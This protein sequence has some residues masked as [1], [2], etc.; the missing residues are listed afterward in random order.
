MVKDKS[1]V[2][3]QNNRN[4]LAQAHRTPNNCL[5]G[6]VQ[7]LTLR[8]NP[9]ENAWVVS[10]SG[11]QRGAVQ[12]FS[13]NL[14]CLELHCVDWPIHQAPYCCLILSGTSRCMVEE[15]GFKRYVLFILSIRHYTLDL[16]MAV[17]R[18][19]F[20][21]LSLNMRTVATKPWYLLFRNLFYSQKSQK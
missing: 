1:C 14:P 16:L 8:H 21:Y 6:A 11:I 7:W 20:H 2:F 4:S 5:R 3:Y 10:R 12:L 13:W 19:T 17:S 15:T 9:S 18:R